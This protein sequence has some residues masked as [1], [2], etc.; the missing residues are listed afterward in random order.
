MGSLVTQGRSFPIVRPF[1]S[2]P[3]KRYFPATKHSLSGDFLKFRQSH[4][5]AQLFGNPI[6]EP[7]REQNGDGTGRVYLIQYFQNARFEYHPELAGTGNDVELG[8]LGKQIL[9]QR[10]WL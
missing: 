2:T 4:H 5:G 6:S 9:Q 8:L 1:V 10:G 7:L 3:I